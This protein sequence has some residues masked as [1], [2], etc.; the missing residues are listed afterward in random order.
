MVGLLFQQTASVLDNFL[1]IYLLLSQCVNLVTIYTLLKSPKMSYTYIKSLHGK[2][3][4][5]SKLQF[6]NNYYYYQQP[7]Q[8]ETAHSHKSPVTDKERM[9]PVGNL[10]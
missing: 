4:R 10:P 7:A 3:L 6:N 8:R 9:R 5:S 1:Y 2:P